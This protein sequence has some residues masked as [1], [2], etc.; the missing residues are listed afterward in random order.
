VVTERFSLVDPETILYEFTVQD[1]ASF[2]GPWG[3]EIPISRLHAELYEYGCHE[4]NYALGGVLS[5]ARYQEGLPR[6]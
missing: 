4:G 3:G 2:T 5:G 1:P 6:D